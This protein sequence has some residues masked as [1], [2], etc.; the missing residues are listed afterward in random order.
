MQFDIIITNPSVGNLSSMP[1]WQ[2]PDWY[3]NRS[4][5][6][7]SIY[8]RIVPSFATGHFRV[9]FCL[10]AKS[11]SINTLQNPLHDNVVP[12]QVHF[13]ANQGFALALVLKPRHKVTRKWPTIQPL[14]TLA[15]VVRVVK[16][17]AVHSRK[18]LSIEEQGIVGERHYLIGYHVGLIG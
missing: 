11:L 9:A 14:V 10:S 7:E 3:V 15:L 2:I 17:G 6:F 5:Y 18:A 16:H 4:P 8:H 12:L 1:I 13:H